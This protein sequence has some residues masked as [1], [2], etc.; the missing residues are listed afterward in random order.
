MFLVVVAAVLV[1]QSDFPVTWKLLEVVG[2]LWVLAETWRW[3]HSQ[4]PFYSLLADLA[5]RLVKG[6]KRS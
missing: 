5:R 2:A 1:L 3:M 4:R 6:W